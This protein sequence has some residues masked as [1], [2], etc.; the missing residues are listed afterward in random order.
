M[1]S[2]TEGDCYAAF[3][4]EE[5]EIQ[6][7]FVEWLA[8]SY[9]LPEDLSVLDMGCGTG[10]L[11]RPLASPGWKVLGM[12]PHPDY[13]AK[14][15]VIAADA[16]EAIEVVPGGFGELNAAGR[17]HLVV[18]VSAP[19]WYL[20]TAKQRADALSRTYRALH[21]SGV[22]F[23]EGPDLEWILEHYRR[24]EPSEARYEG[25]LIRRDPNHEID[26]EQKTWTHIDYFTAAETGE[27]LTTVHR[28]SIL[29][30]AEITDALHQ[31]GF[32]SIRTYSGWRARS[33]GPPEG[34]RVLISGQ[35]PVTA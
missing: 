12:E 27:E 26:R 4:S 19:W 24:P 22:V 18:A 30:T 28:L 5:S 33:P 29:S 16:P 35:R 10:R 14:S 23:L 17:F 1:G 6:Q 15:R 31:A 3:Y 9:N 2:L 20:P 11:L 32:T 34:P 13:L 25:I 7:S 8:S 21:P